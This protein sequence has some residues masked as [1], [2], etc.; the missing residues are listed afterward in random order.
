LGDI[1]L[2]TAFASNEMAKPPNVFGFGTTTMLDTASK[3]ELG[4]GQNSAGPMALAFHIDDKWIYGTV[5]QHW[6]SFS[7]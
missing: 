6:R 3:K 5:V 7:V 4:S 1:V 2:W